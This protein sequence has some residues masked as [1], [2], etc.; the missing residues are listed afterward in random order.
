MGVTKDAMREELSLVQMSPVDGMTPPLVR[1]EW[2]ARPRLWWRLERALRS[3]VVLIA[4]PAGYGKSTL[5]TQ[6]AACRDGSAVA[7]VQLDRA[8][9]DPTR[10]WAH[11]AM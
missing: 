9:N 4:A 1:A 5:L 3:Q 6:W 11:V 7:W 2:V 8:D 10:L